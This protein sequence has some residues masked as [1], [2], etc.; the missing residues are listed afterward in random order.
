MARLVY[1]EMR[2]LTAL[3]MARASCHGG[4]IPLG[5]CLAGRKYSTRVVPANPATDLNSYG[6]PEEFLVVP[7]LSPLRLGYRLSCSGLTLAL[8]SCQL[9]SMKMDLSRSSSMGQCLTV[10][11][12]N[13]LKSVESFQVHQIAGDAVE[14]VVAL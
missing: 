9:D 12:L 2:S 5:W 8:L 1:C 13:G 7:V 10:P 11:K 3:T 4:F 6:N 14:K